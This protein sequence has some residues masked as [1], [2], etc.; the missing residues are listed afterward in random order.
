MHPYTG[1]YIEHG[2]TLYSIIANRAIF[3]FIVYALPSI[4]ATIP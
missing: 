4:A 3:T 1:N 2:L